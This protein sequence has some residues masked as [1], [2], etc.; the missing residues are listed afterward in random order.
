MSTVTLTYD[1]HNS[2]ANSILS[3]ILQSGVF[4][5]S[6]TYNPEFVEKIKNSDTE[7]ASGYYTS[8]ET[9]DLWK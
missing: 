1:N 3:S 5:V 4:A 8:I 2:L 9:D 6:E 7:F